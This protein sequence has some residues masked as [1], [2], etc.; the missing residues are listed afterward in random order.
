MLTAL[1]FPHPQFLHH[2]PAFFSNP[3]FPIAL[4]KLSPHITLPIVWTCPSDLVFF[5]L[6]EIQNNTHFKFGP[7]QDCA[8]L[9]TLGCRRL[10]GSLGYLIKYNLYDL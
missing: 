3:P 7:T 4:C 1:R 5:S 8:V 6:Q 2:K 9:G 10:Y